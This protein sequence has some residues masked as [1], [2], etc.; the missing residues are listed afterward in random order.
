MVTINSLKH[1]ERTCHKLKTHNVQLH[2]M[3]HCTVVN[4]P[5]RAL[6]NKMPL[7]QTTFNYSFIHVCG[8]IIS[9]SRFGHLKENR[10]RFMMYYDMIIHKHLIICL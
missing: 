2:C 3:Q 8:D 4:C 5:M 9:D 1:E 10:E 7:A 6:Q